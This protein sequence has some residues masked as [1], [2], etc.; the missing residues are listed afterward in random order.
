MLFIPL[1]FAVALLLL[2]LLARVV[3]EGG[4]AALLRPFFIL[5]GGYALLSVIIG[6]RWGYNMTGLLPAMSIM[7]AGLSSLAWIAF[8]GLTSTHKARGRNLIHIL[9]PLLVVIL[10]VAWPQLI[11]L[12]LV[13]T[14][15]SYGTALLRLA[16]RGPDALDRVPL[17]KAMLIHRSLIVTGLMLVLSA[18][19]D[20]LISID[21]V[22]AG[23]IHAASYVAVANLFVLLILGIATAI[24]GSSPPPDSSEDAAEPPALQPNDEDLSVATKVENLI[25]EK[26]LYRDPELT[27]NR[28]SRKALIPARHISV[29]INRTKQQSVS[30]YVNG[31]RIAE[32]CR[33]LWETDRSITVIMFES[34]FQTKSNFNRE[35]LRQTGTSP[36]DWRIKNTKKISSLPT[37]EES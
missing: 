36:A 2:L 15:L 12:F 17:E 34:G 31:Y 25:I 3:S 30:Q 23:G 14:H 33:L 37:R 35:F 11:D 18:I 26:Q 22:R 29:A 7:A 13:A 8:H 20:G 10:I 27:L 1:P 4:T 32:A 5:T 9:P 21:F 24:A 19:V 6:L 16:A 28:L